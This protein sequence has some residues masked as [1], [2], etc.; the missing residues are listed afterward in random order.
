MKRTGRTERMSG[1]YRAIRLLRSTLDRSRP[2]PSS[3]LTGCLHEQPTVPPRLCDLPISKLVTWPS[4]VRSFPLAFLMTCQ[5]YTIIPVPSRFKPSVLPNP[6]TEE[7]ASFES[8]ISQ[9]LRLECG[10]SS[11]YDVLS[12]EEMNCTSRAAQFPSTDES[13]HSRLPP[14]PLSPWVP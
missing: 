14:S 5:L 8:G 4:I 12:G 1:G 13:F 3:Y 7:A 9:G 2:K 11:C 6:V 10:R